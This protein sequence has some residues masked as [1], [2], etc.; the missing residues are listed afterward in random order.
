MTQTF[1]PRATERTE[2][3]VEKPTPKKE[4]VTV[5][6]SVWQTW[7][8][9]LLKA[10]QWTLRQVKRLW[11]LVIRYINGLSRTQRLQHAGILLGSIVVLFVF[12]QIFSR[13]SIA[14]SQ[15]TQTASGTAELP[16]ESPTFTTIL[17]SGKS[18]S[19]YGGWTRISPSDRN[20]VYAYTD[21]LNDVSIIISEQPVPDSFKS[22]PSGSVQKLAEG[23][24]ANRTFDVDGT[25]VYIGKSAKG[26]QSLI[27]T[28]R[29]L[30][31]LIKSSETIT[32]DRW[33]TYIKSLR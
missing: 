12:S 13:H 32:D 14:P 33:K 1:T 27:F 24:S 16:K 31:V 18:A 2:P 23:Y 26:P 11:K 25:T 19:D 30:L 28:K 29:D 20:A 9:R 17:P 22:D 3:T 6:T 7:K 10:A 5:T 4:K 8:P 21:K 15:T